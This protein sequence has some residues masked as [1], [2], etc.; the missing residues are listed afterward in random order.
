M[1]Y[2]VVIIGAGFGGIGMAITLKQAGIDHFL[3]VERAAD[4]GGTWRDNSY[5]GQRVP[6]LLHA[7]R[8][9]HQPRRQFDTFLYRYR[10]R[11][12]DL[13]AYRVMPELP[14]TADAA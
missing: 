5:H 4:L 3:V 2:R 6:E 9:Q 12:F 11:R 14:A 1:P 13:A 10:V 7:L 8:A